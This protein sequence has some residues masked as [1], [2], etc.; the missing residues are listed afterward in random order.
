MYGGVKGFEK[1]GETFHPNYYLNEKSF[2]FHEKLYFN[3]R[4]GKWYFSRKH[5]AR[6]INKLGWSDEAYYMLY[7]E[8]YMPNEWRE[9]TTDPKYGDARNR[10][11]CLQCGERKCGFQNWQFDAFCC[12]SCS[13]KWHAVN[14][15]RVER[16]QT[17][18]KQRLAE[19]PNHQLRPNQLQYHLNKGLSLEEAKAA[20]KVRQ[21]TFNRAICIEK[22]GLEEGMVVWQRRQNDW[23]N[24][25]KKSGMYLGV[26]K[27]SKEL[28][29]AV[30][31]HVTGLT[32]EH[33][34]RLG[35][36]KWAKVDC[37]HTDKR[38][39]LEF[40][41]DYW[42]GNPNIYGADDL[43]KG[44]DDVMPVCE[45]WEADK[46]R[47]QNIESVGYKMFIVWE[48]DFTTNREE[49]INACVKFFLED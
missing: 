13:T 27:V 10:P 1:H 4:D 26:S 9:N 23:L 15:D 42:H 37:I 22:H 38:K 14:T 21:T 17:T 18:N 28:I 35:P 3:I 8:E 33:T 24:S 39:V 32:T 41:G 34:V 45:R 6:A 16:A 48:K 44:W 49:T 11:E 31:E 40:Y 36:K 20:Q 5:M 43:I 30:A 46:I 7:G 47:Q 19:N 12:F 29:A 2:T 25:L